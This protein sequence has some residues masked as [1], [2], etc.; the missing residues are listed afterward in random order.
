MRVL[1]SVCRECVVQSIHCV[2][3]T[4]YIVSVLYRED[5]ECVL[6]SIL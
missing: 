2:Y 5:S 1:D 4:E 3:F 6:Q